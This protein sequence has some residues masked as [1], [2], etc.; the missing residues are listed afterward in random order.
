MSVLNN[1]RKQLSTI[2]IVLAIFG[3]GASLISTSP[4]LATS[5]GSS[6]DAT[7]SGSVSSVPTCGYS[8]SGVSAS[9]ALTASGT[10]NPDKP[11]G[12]TTLTGSDSDITISGFPNG[13]INAECSFYGSAPSAPKMKV[14]LSPTPT[15]S[16]TCTSCGVSY[17]IGWSVNSSNPIVVT[18]S[19]SSAGGAGTTNDCSSGG[20]TLSSATLTT[21][22]SSTLV[23]ISSSTPK[24]CDAAITISTGMPSGMN[25]PAGQRAYTVTGPTLTYTYSGS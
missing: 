14:N 10:Y 24:Q 6:S 7:I 9:V 22:T 16:G 25:D 1:S 12:T 11:S 5:Y 20:I 23:A 3:L 15:W 8:L 4:A 19:Q 13:T 18:P 17:K 21:T 2:A